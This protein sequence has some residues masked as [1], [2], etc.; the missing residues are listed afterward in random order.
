MGKSN[1]IIVGAGIGGITT[2]AY[3]AKNGFQ[4]TVYEKNARPG[5]RCGQMSI[6]GHRFDTG[7]TLFLMPEYYARAFSDLG[8]RIE[9]HLELHRVDPAYNLFFADNTKIVLSSDLKEMKSQLEEI[10]QGSF[11][12][13]LR[14]LEEA[15]RNYHL[16]MTFFGDRDFRSLPEFVSPTNLLRLLQVKG[17]T[18]HYDYIGRF[19]KDERL[20]AAFTFQ[21]MYMGLSPFQAPAAFSLLQYSEAADGVWFPTGGMYRVIE[22]LTRIAEK[23]GVKFVYNTPVERINVKDY[24]ASGITVKGG[25]QIIADYIVANADLPYVYQELLPNDRYAAKLERKEYSCSAYTFFWGVDQK[26][27][28]LQ[29]NNLFFSRDYRRYFN[30]VYREDAVP[31]DPMI[32]MHAPTRADPSM[33]PEGQ[34]TLVTIIPVCH[35]CSGSNP[36]WAEL[37]KKARQ[38][39][40]DRLAGIG[41]SDFEKHIK[42]EK[43]FTPPIWQNLY[44]LA[45][46]STHGLGHKLTQ[47]AYFRPQNQHAS[48][49]NLF[50]VGASTH[51]GSGLP[52]VLVS[53]RFATARILIDAGIPAEQ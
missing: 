1:V 7:P 10:E 33:A 21:N 3:L 34:D 51:P 30:D 38:T 24:R 19:F 15:Q 45:K 25:E 53:A 41:L 28:E 14:Y 12:A 39:I 46:G 50:F 44:N 49:K 27:P 47:L 31:D 36:D 11:G 20:K 35:L 37:R 23:H 2:A 22:V 43:C 17:L 16:A 48:Y 4:V 8:E 32:Y 6:D 26:L 40:L 9:D 13:Y 42:F 29:L 5:G 18:K 52:M